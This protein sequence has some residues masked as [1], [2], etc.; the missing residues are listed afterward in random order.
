MLASNSNAS[1]NIQRR[2]KNL[3]F[4]K[5]LIEIY[6]LGFWGEINSFVYYTLGFAE[7]FILE[8]HLNKMPTLSTL[9]ITGKLD[10]YNVHSRSGLNGSHQ[11]PARVR[12]HFIRY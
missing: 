2:K 10:W 9:C 1:D 12:Q 5:I 11:Y 4:P 8:M 3:F 7:M 6:T